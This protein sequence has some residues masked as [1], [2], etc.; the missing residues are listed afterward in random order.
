MAAIGNN[1]ERRHWRKV[2]NFLRELHRGHRI[3]RANY[4]SGGNSD[5]AQ[6][7][8][9]VFSG[10]HRAVV[11]NVAE[12]TDPYSHAGYFGADIFW[13]GRMDQCADAAF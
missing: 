8:P 6:Y 9:Q 7:R 12:G 5:A 10:G 1:V 3:S 2:V 11:P 13:C 4:D